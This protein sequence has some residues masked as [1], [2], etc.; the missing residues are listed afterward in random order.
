MSLININT[1]ELRLFKIYVFY[2]FLALSRTESRRRGP[3][4]N[5]VTNNDTDY[6]FRITDPC[7]YFSV[8][9]RSHE[10]REKTIIF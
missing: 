2:S 3:K 8:N 5:P 6:C 9:D 7:V 4:L 1:H 10:H